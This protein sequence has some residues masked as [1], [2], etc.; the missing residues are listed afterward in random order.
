MNFER[1]FN[2]AVKYIEND[3]GCCPA[4]YDH[5]LEESKCVSCDGLVTDNRSM[6]YNK[7]QSIKCWRDM[8]LR[9]ETENGRIN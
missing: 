1:A 7:E 8:F 9:K 4:N 5:A 6:E 3:C 2:E